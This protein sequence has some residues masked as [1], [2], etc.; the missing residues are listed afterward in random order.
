MELGGAKRGEKTCGTHSYILTFLSTLYTYIPAYVYT[1]VFSLSLNPR[2][3]VKSVV[4][5]KI[6]NEPNCRM[7]M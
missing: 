7:V 6:P 5:K 1:Y 4:S 2:K 3:S